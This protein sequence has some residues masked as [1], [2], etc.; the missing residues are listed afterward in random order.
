[1]ALAARPGPAA[2]LLTLSAAARL[3]GVD[4]ETVR[5]WCARGDLPTARHGPRKESASSGATSSGSA[6]QAA[7]TPRPSQ[8][9]I[10]AAPRRAALLRRGAPPRPRAVVG[11]T[12][13]SRRLASELSRLGR[14]PA[15]VRGGPRELR[16][17]VPRDRAGLWL[18]QPNRE[19]PL[20]LVAGRNHPDLIQERVER[21]TADS[22]LAG[23]EALRR[24][25]VIVFKDHRRPRHHAGDA[26]ALR[27]E[28]RR[29]RCASCPPCS[30]ARRWPSSSST[31]TAPY[32]WSRRRDRAGPEL[33]R[34]DRDRHRQR[35]AHGL[36]G[37]SRRAAPGDPGP[38]GQAV[39]HPGRARHRRDHRRRG[40]LASS[41]TTP[42]GSTASTTTPAGASRSR[43]R[44]CSWAAPTRSRSCYGS[45]SARASPAGSPSTA[46]RSS[47]ATPTRTRAAM[48]V[49]ETTG[50]ESMLVVPMTY[51]GNVRGRRRRVAPGP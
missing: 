8:R 16:P 25:T 46:S 23:F 21:A 50:P 1:M 51:E 30:A 2:E 38:L 11:G 5:A 47:S 10:A 37:G 34:H 15:R 20:E 40:R 32:D 4:P 44:A 22:K 28:R 6:V 14:H 19:H 45:G 26:R 3:A 43:S 18:W 48:I 12:D 49:G 29:A 42:S 41:N 31:T 24:E 39:G 35:P 7:G 36:G 9:A 13:A 33:R 27:Q 17:A